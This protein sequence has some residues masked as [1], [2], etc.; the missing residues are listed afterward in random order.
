MLV[1]SIFYDHQRGS[2]E[3]YNS[4]ILFSPESSPTI[5]FYHKMH[6]VPFG[7][8]VPFIDSLPWLSI[9]TPYHGGRVPQPQFRPRT[10][11]HSR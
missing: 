6:L 4:A 8:Y 5:H 2:L 9:L 3:K 10:A 1:G 11:A 7:E